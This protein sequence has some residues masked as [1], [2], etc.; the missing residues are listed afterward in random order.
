MDDALDQY[1]GSGVTVERRNVDDHAEWAERYGRDVPV[2]T[3]SS[4]QELCRHRLDGD[5]V[6]CW[7]RGGNSPAAAT[8]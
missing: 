2:L 6:R 8:P 4:G 7:L 5:A 1:F 3:T